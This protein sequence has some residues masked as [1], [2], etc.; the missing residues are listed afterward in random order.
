MR[1]LDMNMIRKSGRPK[2]ELPLMQACVY[3]MC[4]GGMLGRFAAENPAD[5]YIDDRV[6]K[7][8][9]PKKEIYQAVAVLKTLA[10]VWGYDAHHLPDFTFH[11]MGVF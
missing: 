7:L 3:T 8:P 6:G 4:G 11:N 10:E 1:K 5:F 2:S 9:Y